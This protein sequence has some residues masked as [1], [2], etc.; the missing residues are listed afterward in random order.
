MHETELLSM[1]RQKC[2]ERYSGLGDVDQGFQN[3]PT[4]G[5]FDLVISHEKVSNVPI[6]AASS[7]EIEL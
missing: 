6:L 4:T 1:E 7:A 2:A 5:A 3:E